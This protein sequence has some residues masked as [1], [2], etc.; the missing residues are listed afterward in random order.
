M[1]W[2]PVITYSNFNFCRKILERYGYGIST[3]GN[4]SLPSVYGPIPMNSWYCFKRYVNLP[5]NHCHAEVDIIVLIAHMKIPNLRK[6]FKDYS[7]SWQFLEWQWNTWASECK[8][9]G[10]TLDS[11]IDTRCLS[12]GKLLGS[13]VLQC[14]YVNHNNS[15]YLPHT[16]EL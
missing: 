16:C 9:K 12:L 2:K 4:H 14:L 7:H 10:L 13:P 1:G 6:I 15:T 3:A 8:G 5:Y 11:G